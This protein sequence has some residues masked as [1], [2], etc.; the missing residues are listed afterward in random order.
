ML[1][2]AFSS[3]PRQF[4]HADT[5]THTPPDTPP[6]NPQTLA[7]LPRTVM[8]VSLFSIISY[9]LVDLRS[10]AG[11]FFSYDFGLILTQLAAESIALCVS[12]VAATPQHAAAMVPI[13]VFVD[14]AR[15]V[16]SPCPRTHALLVCVCGGGGG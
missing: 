15:L 13:F 16:T 7:E 2:V 12:A 10:G 11:H 3:S 14:P 1:P 4:T 5:P 6:H 9:F 8:F